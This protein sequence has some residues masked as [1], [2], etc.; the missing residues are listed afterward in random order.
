[1]NRQG[2]VAGILLFGVAAATACGQTAPGNANVDNPNV[3][4]VTAHA[5]PLASTSASVTVLTRDY[6]ES[7]HAEN[8]ADLLRAAPF[9]QIAQSG[10][11]GGLTTVTIRGGKPNFTL[12]MIDG[13]EVNDITT[14]LGGSFDFSSLPIDNIEQ[15]EIVRG[16][17]SS[18]YGSDAIGGVINFISRRGSR[19]SLLDV[20]G[21]LGNFMRRQFK[22]SASGTW[23]ALQYSTA[24]SF[25][26]I[27]QQVLNDG[28][29]VGSASFNGSVDLGRKR[30][31]Q[32]EAR[33]TNDESTG[34]PAGSGGPELSILRQPV[35]DHAI[36]L[37][38]GASFK[39]E[40][41][42]WWTYS[43]DLDRV[44]RTENNESPAVLDRIPPSYNSLPSSTSYTDFTRTHFG[45][46]SQFTLYR[47]LSLNLGAGVRDEQGSTAGYLNTTIP[48]SFSIGRTSL[49]ANSELE[50]S[51]TRLTATAGFGFDKTEGYGEVTSPRV[52][53]SWLT[54]EG[55]PRLK[56]SWAK[57][58]KLPSFYALGN[59]VIGNPGLRPERSRS[60]DAG[61]EQDLKKTRVTVSA[62]YFRNDFTDL[63][64][65]STA[66]FHLLNRSHALTQGAEF[67]TDYAPT[68]KIKFG[69][70]LSY[71]VW[72]LGN[73]TQPLRN[74]P[75]ADGGIHLDWKFSSR[76]RARVETQWMG[77]RYDF[78]IPVPYETSVGGYSNTSLS[79]DY[80]LNRKLS[81]YLRGDNLLDSKYHEYIGFPNPGISIRAGL[82]YRVFGQ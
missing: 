78:Q 37:L 28:Y 38:L 54:K 50:Y 19:K 70:D 68:A 33:Y 43:I 46:T 24:G 72:E 12:V 56:S 7:S 5:M 73:T 65:F 29:S 15:V 67:G 59:P 45:A 1:M 26:D 51:T 64:D 4:T 27:G 22:V 75:H 42:P 55:G 52:G 21:E 2:N 32:F 14:T 6:I 76:L 17:L 31:L 53:V 77:R 60:F 79:A 3:V 61:V 44:N 10:A 69:V 71:T 30:V 20:S 40:I 62:T 57:G 63:V 8:A 13:I 81:V 34:F 23:K 82:Q 49:L 35:S 80:D 66:T 47:D 58:F 41:R 39:G 18:V 48:E 74:V 11:S 36:E 9:L 16:P 25:L